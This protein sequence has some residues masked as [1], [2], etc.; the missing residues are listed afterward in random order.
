MVT[1]GNIPAFGTLV[2]RRGRNLALRV[3][4]DFNVISLEF[5]MGK[6][7]VL[8]PQLTLCNCVPG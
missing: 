6:T 2:K 7:V 1:L 5:V 8:E 3:V 4:T